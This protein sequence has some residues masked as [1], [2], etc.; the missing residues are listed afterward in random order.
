MSSNKNSRELLL[1]TERKRRWIWV[2]NWLA[3]TFHNFTS[4]INVHNLEVIFHQNLQHY[5][6]DL[7][8][9]NINKLNKGSRISK[10]VLEML[11]HEFI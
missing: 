1:T 10:Y 5:S 3:A 6:R 7:V 4:H 11:V 8:C 2:A 9:C